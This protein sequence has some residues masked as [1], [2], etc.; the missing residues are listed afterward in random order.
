[1]CVFDRC[2]EEDQPC[3]MSELLFSFTFVCSIPCSL[4]LFTAGIEE[5]QLCIRLSF[6]SLFTFFALYHIHSVREQPISIS[7]SIDLKVYGK[8]ST[9]CKGSDRSNHRIFKYSRLS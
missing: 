5:K 8:T 3:K 2:I 7:L 6:C 9:F 4:S 1:M